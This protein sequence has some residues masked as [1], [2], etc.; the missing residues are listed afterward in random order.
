MGVLNYNL[1]KEGSKALVN[2][3]GYNEIV[4]IGDIGKK[5]TDIIFKDGDTK[6]VALEEVLVEIY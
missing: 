4:T 5:Y 1:I 6:K 2:Y 3:Y